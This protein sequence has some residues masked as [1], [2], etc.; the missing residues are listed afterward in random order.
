MVHEES[1]TT[2]GQ[3]QIDKSAHSGAVNRFAVLGVF[4]FFILLAA[5]IIPNLLTGFSNSPRS[6]TV[7]DMRAIGTAL[8]SYQVDVKHFPLL[9]T[10]GLFSEIAFKTKLSEGMTSA[11]YEGASKDAW[12]GEFMYVGEPTN[13]T[14]ISFGKDRKP[15]GEGEFNSD[16]V[17]THGVFIAPSSVAWP[18]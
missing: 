17:Y 11:Y 2:V 6:R 10:G 7:A 5:A 18:P 4:I 14:L 15:G 9:Q 13:Y 8:G 16:I 3:Q 1:S 12:R